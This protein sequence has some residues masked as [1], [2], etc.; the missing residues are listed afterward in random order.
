MCGAEFEPIHFS[1]RAGTPPGPADLSAL[2]PRNGDGFPIPADRIADDADE[3]ATVVR[4]LA[5]EDQHP[6][7][8][9]PDEG[10]EEAARLARWLLEKEKEEEMKYNRTV[11]IS[12]LPDT[13]TV[14][15]V[16]PRIR[17][18]VDSC[19]VSQFEDTRVAV[20]TFKLPA[21]AITYVEFCAETPIWSLWTFQI[22]RPGVPFTW[23][24]R[25]KVQ[26][27]KSA[28]GIGSAWDRA[29]IPTQHRIVVPA[30]SRCLVYKDCKPHE[31][32]GIYRALGLHISQ[33]QRDQVESMWLDGPVRDHRG[34]PICGNLHVWYTSIRAAQ[35]AKLRWGPLE[36]EYDP[37]SDAPPKLMLHLDE[38]NE[39][40]IFRHHEP[41]V[42]MIEINQ[43]TILSG[44]IQGIVDPA[45]AYWR[46]PAPARQLP[47]DGA[48]LASRLQWSLQ[49]HGGGGGQQVNIAT[50]YQPAGVIPPAIQLTDPFIDSRAVATGAPPQQYGNRTTYEL[51]RFDPIPIDCQPF[52][53]SRAVPPEHYLSPSQTYVARSQ[54][55]QALGFPPY[56]GASQTDLLSRLRPIQRPGPHATGTTDGSD[57]V[58]IGIIGLDITDGNAGSLTTNNTNKYSNLGGSHNPQSGRQ[59]HP[60]S[61]DS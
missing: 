56:S 1:P 54:E 8:P 30:G 5:F 11:T 46:C 40:S 52:A 37:C 57:G 6:F 45:Q 27:F 23:E 33:H 50:P 13:A 31:V 21:D 48:S 14:A 58:G 53:A 36:Y 19:Y 28:P 49:S 16:L 59:P 43:K 32:A 44:V 9:A 10:T 22:S 12:P 34:I 51:G 35:A 38:G 47:D 2:L 24:R 15:D 7:A 17:G 4:S 29:D 61:Y 39:V 20:V 25:A 41:F 26:L 55:R 18:G 60:G 42:N 3:P